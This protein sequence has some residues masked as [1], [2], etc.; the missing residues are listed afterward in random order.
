MTTGGRPARTGVPLGPENAAEI[1][2]RLAAIRRPLAELA[3]SDG[4]Y[5]NLRLFAQAHR[6]EYLPG[7]WP[8]VSGLAYDGAP[9]LIPLFDLATAPLAVLGELQGRDAEFY[10]V[11][12]SVLR[13]MDPPTIVSRALRDDADYL[14][15][16][17]PFIDYVDAG[18]GPKRH[19]LSRLLA[20]TPVE[21]R[22]LDRA[23]RGVALAVLEGW[24]TDK[25]HGPDGADA[26][27]CRAALEDLRPGGAL[28]GFLH[29]AGA[30]PIGFVL[31][32]W[33]NPGVLAVRFAK[34]RSAFDGI[35]PHLFQDLARRFG[36]D[37]QW[38]NFE[39]DLGLA[40]FR[41]T[42]QSYRPALLVAKHRVRV[43]AS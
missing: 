17:A 11:A 43:R 7:P 38:L 27:A 28:F 8:C 34:G 35:F 42:K 23:D 26:A 18:L 29:V 24:C 13:S 10:P 32:E 6:Y 33:L 21:V 30:I 5:S 4:P 9:V 2:A 15:R 12:E 14:Y 39:Q 41:R 1:E 31:V 40:N 25:Q 19:A 20:A 16:S 36:S 3:P 37:L 22:P